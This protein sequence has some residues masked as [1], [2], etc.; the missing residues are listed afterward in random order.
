MHYLTVG[1]GAQPER[2]RTS[3]CL[4]RSITVEE[5]RSI[6]G[7]VKPEL[8][9]QGLTNTTEALH[10]FAMQG[11]AHM[12]RSLLELGVD[13][14]APLVFEAVLSESSLTAR[15]S[16]TPIASAAS[17]RLN[18]GNWT[19]IMAYLCRGGCN[20]ND[21]PELPNAEAVTALHAAASAGFLDRVGWLLARGCR[22]SLESVCG[23]LRPLHVAAQGREPQHAD[24]VEC[25]LDHDAVVNARA[26]GPFGA[27][28]LHYAVQLG[29]KHTV[30]NLLRRGADVNMPT[31]LTG[32]TPLHTTI[33]G[34]GRY[35]SRQ[36]F[37]KSTSSRHADQQM[38]LSENRLEVL[39]ALLRYRPSLRAIDADKMTALHYAARYQEVMF[40]HVLIDAAQGQSS[41]LNMEC[42]GATAYQMAWEAVEPAKES[43][44]ADMLERHATPAN[45]AKRK[46]S[47]RPSI[48]RRFTRRNRNM[49]PAQ[50]HLALRVLEDP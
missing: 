33:V 12:V 34:M 7:H 35:S 31:A 13:A 10:R 19:E 44:I 6:L 39:K 47:T 36:V 38:G 41:F 49:T 50:G 16:R 2:R 48:F 25:L 23:G 28:A 40:A 15:V 1:L 32:R 42:M 18:Q 20:V 9:R 21:K 27:T 22:N 26:D 24:I 3:R 29:I 45:V 30:E 14:D 17:I 11:D 8:Q 5:R 46:K 43:V 4:T 37:P